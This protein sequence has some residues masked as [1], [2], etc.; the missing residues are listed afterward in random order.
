MTTARLVRL[1]FATALL[2]AV[3]F[4]A[5]IL[6]LL[7]SP[8]WNRRTEEPSL[9]LINCPMPLLQRSVIEHRFSLM[10]LSVTQNGRSETFEFDPF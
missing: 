6:A 3:I 7:R 9:A 1:A 5:E 4:G 2:I 8:I 10:R